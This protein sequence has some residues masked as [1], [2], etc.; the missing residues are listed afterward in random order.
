MRTHIAQRTL[1]RTELDKALMVT[2]QM[3]NGRAFATLTTL[4]GSTVPV[5]ILP[6]QTLSVAFKN[7]SQSTLECS[8]YTDAP[9]VTSVKKR[10]PKRPASRY[11]DHRAPLDTPSLDTSFHDSEMD[12]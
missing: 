5:E 2:V 1:H 7:A 4:T 12:V 10:M 11:L 9:E 6:G 3:V 8:A